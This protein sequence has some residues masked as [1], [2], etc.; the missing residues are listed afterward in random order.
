M[1]TAILFLALI[2]AC[3]A[4]EYIGYTYDRYVSEYQKNHAPEQIAMRKALFEQRLQEI[5]EHNNNPSFTWQVGVNQFTDMT[6]EELK[7]FLTMNKKLLYHSHFLRGEVT[8]QLPKAYE[9][10]DLP[11]S[12]D[13][14]TKGIITNVKNQGSCGSCWS[15]GAAECIESMWA[16]KTGKLVVLSEQNIL[17]CTPNP[18]HCGGTGGCGGGTAELAYDR[19]KDIGIAKEADYPYISGST[20]RDYACKKNYPVTANLTGYVSITTNQQPPLLEALANVGP[21][22]VNVEATPWMSY[23]SGVFDGC[24]QKNP[25]LNH[26][27]QLVGYGTD[28]RYGDFWLVRNSW[29]A[30]W[31]ESGYIRLK[32]EVTPRCGEDRT[33]QDGTGC[34]G[35]PPVVTVC[36][37]CG[38]LY[39]NIYPV[40]NK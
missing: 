16:Q 8:P 19:I 22:A 1:K 28:T 34:D 7:S 24:N 4:S 25:D 9:P 35:G 32:R 29:G 27:V 31:G 40:F 38:I 26:V 21:L 18:K 11:A 20:G 14:R 30:G 23:R 10:K 6:E 17:D 12:V 36:G 13:W 37:T 39:D 15:F 3:L 33:P 2:L 5:I